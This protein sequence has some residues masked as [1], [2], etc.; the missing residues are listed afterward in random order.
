MSTDREGNDR[1]EAESFWK[2][3]GQTK[4]V[5][6]LV[7]LLTL[8]LLYPFLES[9]DDTYHVLT[10]LTS[11][12]LIAGVIAVAATRRHA[13]VAVLL[14]VPTA[15]MGW[16]HH[17]TPAEWVGILGDSLAIVFFGF[18]TLCV[19]SYVLRGT[20]VSADKLYGATCVYLLMGLV[21][22]MAYSLL[23]K[24]QPGSFYAAPEQNLDGKLNWSDLLFFSFITLT[25]IGYGDITPVTSQARSLAILEAVAG[26]MFLTV[27]VAR[28]I[29]LY[30]PPWMTGREDSG[31]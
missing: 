21:W 6:L 13:I 7:S 12:S 25:T 31:K 30:V 9:K 18:T 23:E 28:L 2:R 1:C 4:C 10:V 27:L 5:W 3:L 20:T 24:L 17:A 16:L 29:G 22:A 8:L 26:T 19:L 11:I 15:V 14:G